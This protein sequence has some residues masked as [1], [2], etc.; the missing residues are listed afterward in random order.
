[1]NVDINKTKNFVKAIFTSLGLSNRYAEMSIEVILQAELTGVLTHGLAKLP[2]YVMRYKNKSENI[3]PKI[4]IMNNH[5]NN[6]LLDGDNASGLIVGPEALKICIRS[7]KEK[8][9]AAVAVKNS[10]HFG[11]GNYYS[12]KFAEE[13]LIGIV[14]T[15]SAPLMAPYG[16]KEREIGTNP[17]TVAIPANHENPIILDMA[18]SIAAYGKIQ[19]AAIVN[20]KIPF[21]WAN[22]KDGMVT[23]NPTEALNGTLQPLGGYKGYG[24]AVIVDAL[25]S[26]LSHGEFG[27]NISS[28]E[29]LSENSSEKISHFMLGIDPSTFYDIGDFLSYVDSYV[30]YIKN[31]PKAEGNDEI[32]LPGEIEF[33][34]YHQ[35]IEQGLTIRNETKA[36][37]LQIANDLGLNFDDYASLEELISNAY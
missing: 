5:T 31:S 18:S 7:A 1:M 6:I 28:V 19:V 27:K 16:G 10:G 11:C 8:G 15:N 12:W 4:K 14:M 9:I 17:I 3:S 24:L 21:T 2:F 13:N 23:D 33:N 30:K 37:L 34:K 36:I 26:L 29:E 22:N 20:E 32:F 35:N 25:T